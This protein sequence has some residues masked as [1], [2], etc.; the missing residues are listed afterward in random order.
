MIL[1]AN[2]GKG[3]IPHPETDGLVKAVIV[4]VTP[5]KLQAGKHGPRQVSQIVFET[6]VYDEENERFFCVWGRSFTMSLHEK[7]ALKKEVEQIYGRPLTDLE[8]KGWD[9][10]SLI[11]FP[12]KLMVLHN[13]V[14]ANVSVIV[15]DKSEDPKVASGSYTRVKDRKTDD[16]AQGW[17]D[18]E[19]VVVHVGKHK[20]TEIGDLTMDDVQNLVTHWIPTA[21]S[22]PEDVKLKAALLEVLDIP[23]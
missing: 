1:K 23:Y 7:S 5:Q 13:G 9:T 3:F 4:D 12:V 10:E 19:D 21:T 6:E 16:D 22:S 18:A 11:G 20:G 2:G 8:K 17:N 15:P 14:Y